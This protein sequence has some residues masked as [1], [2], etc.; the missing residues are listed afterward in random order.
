M[1][2][3]LRCLTSGIPANTGVPDGNARPSVIWNRRFFNVLRPD[4]S[5]NL[6][7]T[8]YVSPTGIITQIAGANKDGIRYPLDPNASTGIIGPVVVSSP[9]NRL[10]DQVCEFSVNPVNVHNPRDSMYRVVNAVHNI[11][12]TGSALANGGSVSITPINNDAEPREIG[13]H[14]GT[15][16]QTR[17]VAADNVYVPPM[18]SASS[19]VGSA[20]DSLTLIHLPRDTS[21]HH[22]GAVAVNSQTLTGY[23]ITQGCAAFMHHP[24]TR[25]Y[26][27]SYSGLDATASITIDSRVCIQET[28]PALDSLQSLAKPSEM[29]DTN[30][31]NNFLGSASSS[32]LMGWGLDQAK[33][34]VMQF[35]RA[36]YPVLSKLLD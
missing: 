2:R 11:R 9:T 25:V 35:V 26:V 18:L 8:L 32:R 23:E 34:I 20:R 24:A 19:M 33:R 16:F 5:G 4:S 1:A 22:T 30:V 14:G 13:M 29:T 21:Y 10:A 17:T 31:L 15:D 36:Q 7:F 6:V 12:F 27:L 28:V 3:Y